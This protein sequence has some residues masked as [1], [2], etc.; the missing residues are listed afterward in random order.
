M[1]DLLEILISVSRQIYQ[2][3]TGEQNIYENIDYVLKSNWWNLA[4]CYFLWGSWVAN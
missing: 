4:A 1:I 2:K 3:I